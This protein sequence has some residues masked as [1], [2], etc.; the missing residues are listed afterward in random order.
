MR[1][2]YVGGSGPKVPRRGGHLSNRERVDVG[3]VGPVGNFDCRDEE[4]VLRGEGGA[5]KKRRFERRGFPSSFRGTRRIGLSRR[6]ARPI[7]HT[8][9]RRA[10]GARTEGRPPL[11]ARDR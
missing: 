3:G 2:R 8:R 7:S 5:D 1:K 6:P 10:A 4:A 9:A 11:G